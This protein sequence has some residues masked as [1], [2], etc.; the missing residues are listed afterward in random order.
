MIN[1]DLYMLYRSR[2]HKNR[3]LCNIWQ[4]IA[5][6]GGMEY[7]LSH[8]YLHKQTWRPSSCWSKK[9][10]WKNSILPKA[11]FT[12]TRNASAKNLASRRCACNMSVFL[13]GIID[14]LYDYIILGCHHLNRR[15]VALNKTIAK[16]QHYSLMSNLTQTKGRTAGRHAGS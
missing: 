8:I 6:H 1:L 10:C 15:T 16:T 9:N 5:Y 12:Y 3:S 14:E 13:T 2:S 11:R 7:L 4:K